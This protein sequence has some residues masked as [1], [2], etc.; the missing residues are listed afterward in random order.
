[1]KNILSIQSHVVYGH[2]GNSSAVFPMQRLGC[3]VW[4]IH[5]VQFSNH[6]QYVE[7]W[8]GKAF[9]ASDI[10]SLID[11]LSNLNVLNTCDAILTGYLGSQEQCDS[12]LQTLNRIKTVNPAT[13]Y[14]CDPVMG[15]VNKGCILAPGI[16]KRLV[17]DIMPIADVI[18]P[19]QFELTKFTKIDIHNVEDAVRACKKALKMGPDVVLVKHVHA[20]S[21]TLFSMMYADSTGC[22]LIQR[23]YLSF[24]K[25]PV[26]VGDLISAIFTAKIVNG[27]SNLIAFKHTAEAVFGILNETNKL[28]QWE[29]A[30]VK[31]Q[32]EIFSPTN[33]FEVQ[34]LPM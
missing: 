27:S 3:E 18:I 29:L 25:Q 6:T 11:G 7:G 14:I 30:T 2:A 34:K 12:I 5:T 1:M 10:D 24:I 20:L 28:K 26:G 9:P 4:P 21:D 19:N 22:Y 8:K 23:P 31:F 13:I 15:D 16:T 17:E 32:S 33:H